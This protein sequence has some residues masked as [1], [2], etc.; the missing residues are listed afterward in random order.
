MWNS[1]RPCTKVSSGVHCHASANA[2]MSAAMARRLTRTPF[3]GPVV[4]EVYMISAVASGGGSVIAVP[5]T[6][7]QPHRDVRQA[8]RLVGPLP[9][10]HLGTRV[11]ED[12]SPFGSADVG[13]HRNHRHPGDQAAGD[14]QHG[15]GRRRGEHRDPVRTADALGHRRRGADEVAAAEHGTVDAHRVADVGAARDRRGVQRGQKH[16]SEATRNGSAYL[17]RG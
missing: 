3:G 14:G 12:V 10:P 4:P 16:A 5:R 17:A 15:G 2:S 13:G 7:V 11:G 1:G 8:R 9:Q 6:R